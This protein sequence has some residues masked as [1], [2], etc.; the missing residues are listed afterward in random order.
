MAERARQYYHDNKEKRREYQRNRCQE[1][2]N[3]RQLWR[4]IDKVKIKKNEMKKKARE[5]SK[6][7][8]HNLVITVKQNSMYRG[9]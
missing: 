7:R 8:Y 5:Y 2:K 3:N 6:N 9:R 1:Q 4:L